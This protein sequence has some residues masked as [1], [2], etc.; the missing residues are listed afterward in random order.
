MFSYKEAAQV[1]AE[2]K[3]LGPACL[4]SNPTWEPAVWSQA[5]CT[6]S[7]CLSFLIWKSGITI[8]PTLWW[9]VGGGLDRSSAYNTE[10]RD[11][12][13]LSLQ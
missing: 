3:L 10:N 6:P 2:A 4:G 8:V 5:K 12:S 11:L 9:V 1:V 7:L 13:R